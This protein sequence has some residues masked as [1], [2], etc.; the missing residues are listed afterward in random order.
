ME[1][2]LFPNTR[3]RIA[4]QSARPESFSIY[5]RLTLTFEVN[6]NITAGSQIFTLNLSFSGELRIIKE[7]GPQYY[8]GSLIPLEPIVSVPGGSASNFQLG[9]NMSHYDLGQIERIR[10]G[11]DLHLSANLRFVAEIQEQPQTRRQFG[12]QIEFRIP[13]SDWV[14]K[15]LPQMGYKTV[16]LLEIP[17]LIGSEFQDIVKYL[18]EAWK[19]HSM[20]AYDRVLTDCRKALEALSTKIRAEG[21]E[22]EISGENIREKTIPDWGRLLGN[23]DLGE[24]M[25]TI[26]RKIIGFVAP[27][28][29]AGKSINKE[30]ADFALMTSYAFVNMA[31]RKLSSP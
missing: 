7:A 9:L 3:V 30:D 20:G 28:S 11:K 19:Q 31:I 13:K 14:E 2:G 27:G 10:E 29:H 16:S 26:N 18:D 4:Y 12:F 24:I 6:H 15:F 8:L 25:G 22:K 21:Y 1:V 5:P 23:E 17:Q